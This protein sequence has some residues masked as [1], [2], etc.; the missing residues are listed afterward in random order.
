MIFNNKESFKQSYLNK[1]RDL[2]GEEIEEG[3]NQQKYEAL[4]SLIRDY[5]VINW[6]KT[7]KKYNTTCEKQLYYF[8]MEF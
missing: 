8:S 4:G 3:I 5:V 6:M 1:Y 7:N 2:H